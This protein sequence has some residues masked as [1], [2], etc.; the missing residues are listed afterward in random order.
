MKEACQINKSL[1][2]LTDV[3][4]SLAKQKKGEAPNFVR[5]RDSKLTHFLKDSLGGGNAYLILL[6]C[7]SMEEK[8]VEDSLRT[9]EFARSLKNIKVQEIKKNESFNLENHL[10]AEEITKKDL[11]IA[12][13]KA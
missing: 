12:E 10:Y 3:V 1:S 4:S 11:E 8:V 5:F 2:V 7:I 9:I 13:L 6:A